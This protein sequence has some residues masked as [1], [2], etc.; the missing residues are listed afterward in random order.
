MAGRR[1]QS[2][3]VTGIDIGSTSIRVAVGQA[4]I[5]KELGPDVQLIATA[6]VD[7]NGVAKGSIT[8]IE[9]AVSSVAHALEDI[10]RLIG[11]PIETAWVGINGTQVLFQ[12]SRGAVA[13]A[14]QDGEISGED[15]LRVVESAQTITSPLNFEVLHV[16]PK[17]YCVDGQTGI[18]DP[19][20]MTGVRLEADAQI[21]FGSTPHVKNIMKAVYR[22]GI[23]VDDLVL[24]VL[25]VS[26]VV[27]TQKQKELG[28]VVA[29]IGGETTTVAVYEEGH[30]IHIGIVPIGA[31][32]ITNDLALGLQ[33]DIDIAERVKITY[34]ECSPK[35]FTKKDIIDLAEFG[36]E[37]ERVSKKF[38]AEIINARVAEIFEKINDELMQIDRRALLP[39][40]IVFT[41]GGAKLHGLVEMAKK[42]MG[43]NAGHG[44]PLH[45]QSAT[46][47]INDLSYTTAIGLM[48]WGAMETLRA[49]HKGGKSLVNG[50]QVAQQMRKIFK[51]LIP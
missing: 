5:D 24:G 12:E 38:V 37:G 27:L 30:M 11:A 7:S 3:I 29:D 48:K 26:D 6:E 43:M 2:H 49:G 32:H 20:G 23:D 16:L 34:G 1:K 50:A 8:S 22:T 21:I 40:G 10:E 41:G 28:V 51:F 39:A 25:A 19:V 47:K 46:E 18:K 42:Y 36:A 14:K 33:T 31:D 44:Y 13:V 9:E 4:S 45:L 35:G 17:S 15:V